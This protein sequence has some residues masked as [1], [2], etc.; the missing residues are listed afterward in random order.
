MPAFQMVLDAGFRK[1]KADVA[2][3]FNAVSHLP[4]FKKSV[5]N[6]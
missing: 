5:G 6:I 4:D 1:G 3:W 2:K